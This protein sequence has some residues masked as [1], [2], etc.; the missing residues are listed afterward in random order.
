MRR[1]ILVVYLTVWMQPSI[2]QQPGEGAYLVNAGDV[3]SV[4]VWQEPD[5]Q[6]ETVVRPDGFIGFPLAGEIRAAGHTVAEI[7]QMLASKIETYIPD[8]VV[9]VSVQSLDGYKVYVIGQVRNPGEFL[10]N[11]HVDVMRALAMAQ[12]TTEFADLNGIRVLR[13]LNGT[14]STLRFNYRDIEKGERLEQ[15]VTL[16]AGDV[17]IV[18]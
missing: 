16:Q 5:L 15:N 9:T 14:Q 18:P 12:G 4:S 6:R 3:L 7:Q 8:P 13:R 2:A 1:A 10:L 17:I 11:T